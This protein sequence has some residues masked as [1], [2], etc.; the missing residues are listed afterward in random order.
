MNDKQDG[1]K[2]K[3]EQKIFKCMYEL[4]E[5]NNLAER[6]G[7]SKTSAEIKKTIG[8]L[9]CSYNTLQDQKFEEA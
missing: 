6:M 8:D 5:L 1:K 7:L 2:V 4:A 9:Y 3:F